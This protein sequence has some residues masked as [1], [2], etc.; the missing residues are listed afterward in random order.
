VLTQGISITLNCRNEWR[1]EIRMDCKYSV[2]VPVFQ[3]T[4]LVN[5]LIRHV[6][7]VGGG[8]RVE[9]IVVDGDPAG[10]TLAAI[11]DIE[12]RRLLSSRGR[13][14][15]LNRGV[16]GAKGGILLFLHADTMLPEN[17]FDAIA[18]AF[19]DA[20]LVAGAFDL[21]IASSRPAFRMIEKLASCRSRITRIPY[22]DQAFFIRA[23]YFRAI[24]GFKDIPIMEDVDLMRRIKRGGGKIIILNERVR[25]SARRWEDEGVIYCTLRNWALMAAYLLGAR[26]EKL[27]RFYR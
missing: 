14:S 19:E 22:G 25:T 6:R 16:C 24:G 10:S 20:S 15:Q 1:D 3:E 5:E 9:I 7:E 12:V 2:V 26:P 11:E 17:A 8:H 4:A 23:A 21:G 13:G 18:H 27:L